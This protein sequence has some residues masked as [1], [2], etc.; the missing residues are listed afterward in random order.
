MLSSWSL[1]AWLL[2]APHA[3]LI[4][5]TRDGD[6]S[7]VAKSNK[8]SKTA[9]TLHALQAELIECLDAEGKVLRAIRPAEEHDPDATAPETP[10][11]LATDPNAAMLTHFAN[12]LHRAYEHSTNVAFEKMVELVE[13]LDSRSESVERRLER[14]EAAYRRTVQQQID[15]AVE[16]AEEIA[17]QT[18]EPGQQLDAGT[19]IKTFLTGHD[20]QRNNGKARP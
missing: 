14:T 12:L 4:R 19:L 18:L 11:V 2:R 15:D 13:R 6:T 17:E 1:R 9:D 7:F 8:W 5:V 3:S 16:R 20:Q 10:Q